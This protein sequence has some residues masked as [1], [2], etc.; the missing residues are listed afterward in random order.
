MGGRGAR[1]RSCWSLLRKRALY[2]QVAKPI[3][4][5]MISSKAKFKENVAKQSK[6]VRHDPKLG[7]IVASNILCQIAV[8]LAATTPIYFEFRF[9]YWIKCCTRFAILGGPPQSSCLNAE[10]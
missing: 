10:T 5:E 6:T 7:A 3:H 1:S 2:K 4:D 8:C 9:K